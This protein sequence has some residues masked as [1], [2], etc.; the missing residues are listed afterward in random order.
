ISKPLE[1][2]GIDSFASTVDDG[3]TFMTI[4]K[5]EARSKKQEARSTLFQSQ[6]TSR[7]NNFRVHSR[8]S[9]SN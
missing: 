1:Q 3:L 7:I 5:Q 9:P 6:S 8:E 2:E 4:N